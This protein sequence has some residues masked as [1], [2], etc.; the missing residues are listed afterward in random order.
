MKY[1]IE[2]NN[3][4]SFNVFEKNK[5]YPRAYFIPFSSKA[6][7]AKTDFRDERTS[8]DI[9][10]LLSGEWDFKFY[11]KKSKMPKEINTKRLKF[12][13]VTV[14]STW[15]RAGYQEPVY[16]N[17]PYEFK[18]MIPDVPEDMPVGMYRK[19]FD[20]SDLQ[21]DY[22]LTFLGVSCCLDVYINGRHIGYSEGSHNTAEFDITPYLI[23]GT[24]ELL[25]VSFKWCNGSFLE[26]QDM[27]RENG[28]FRDVYI[29]KNEKTHIYDYQIKTTKTDDGYVLSTEI[30]IVGNT[31][32]CSIELELKKGKKSISK[33]NTFAESETLASF[34]ELDVEEWSAEIPNLYDLFITLKK[35]NK[36][37]MSIRN[38]T[39]FKTI[40]IDKEV[41][42]FNGKKI[43]IKG[44]NH[45]DTHPVRSYAMN[46]EDLE[47]D[48]KLMKDLNVNGVR[49]SHYP[50]DPFLLTLA[51]VYGLY[52]IDEADIE[53]H[54][55]HELCG[56][57]NAISHDLKWVKHYI[58][59]VKRMYYRDRN[60]PSITMWSLGNEAGGYKCHDRC[61]KYLKS[62][63]PEI[64]VHY[65]GVVRTKRIS[66][67]VI[68]EM[69]QHPYVLQKMLNHKRGKSFSGKPY[70]L[71]EYC[72]AMGVG[73]GAMEEYWDIIYA[74]DQFMGGCIWEWADHAVYHAPDDKKYKYK[75][76]YGGDHGE[77]QHDGNFCVD[78]LV[79]PD[80]TPHTGAY[81]MKTVYR[82]IRAKLVKDGIY[83]FENTNRFRSSGYINIKW[84]LLENGISIDSGT[85]K[86]DIAPSSSEEVAIK[87]KKTGS[88]KD[89]HINFIYLDKTNHIATEQLTLNDIE[90]EYEVEIG[91]KISAEIQNNILTVQ[92][93]NGKAEFNVKT[94]ILTSYT[95][96]ST[97][98]VNQMP[99]E[100][101]GF[102]INLFRALLDNDRRPQEFWLKA[103]LDK[104]NSTLVKYE[105]ELSEDEV[106]IEADYQLKFKNKTLYNAEIT[107]VISSKGVLD[108]KASIIACDGYNIPLDI[109][110]FGLSLELPACFENIKYYG[111][112]EKENMPDMKA[113]APIGIYSSKVK[114]MHEPYIYPQENGVHCDV[115]WLEITDNDGKGFI[116]Y[117]DNKLCFNAHNYTRELL[118]KALHEEDVVDQNTT[119]LQIDGFVRGTG[120]SSCGPD[121]LDKYLSD[122]SKEIELKFA[123]V[124]IK[125]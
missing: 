65:E 41:F 40:E 39:G 95:V 18:T 49:T 123:I 42:Y 26:A 117:A 2:M 8:S 97:E 44:V 66:Y 85:L 17:C 10:E 45:H 58:D 116:F 46:F 50:P 87:H 84:E 88:D 34:P 24:N 5:L 74:G 91:N 67:D 21:K 47:K 121:T 6:L 23:Q 38:L 28:I 35:N 81:Q 64:P 120:T 89:Y 125:S 62:V 80:R 69:Y 15:Q 11:K 83:R 19:F 7:L 32:G 3:H 48:I 118:M 53:T 77:K 29:S 1:S 78:G 101:Q 13:K 100:K 37:L 79:F 31:Q 54:G 56:N 98:L 107:Y 108:I 52:V 73:P 63:S 90:Y 124:P 14:P 22:I 105:V 43:K 51:D 119:V 70:Y 71:C 60:H 93:D 59:R 94:G 112:G 76:T 106:E 61:Y 9:V 36:E 113:H 57:M 30:N 72:H 33:I 111:R 4:N 102:A 68:S 109:P 122:L 25:A 75:Y 86:L 96:E 12:D 114:D 55:L 99:V 103:G 110:R 20:V 27:F 82:P 104:L 16:L 92:F 115:K